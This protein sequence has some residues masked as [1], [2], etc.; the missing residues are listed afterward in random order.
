[1]GRLTE[2]WKKALATLC[3]LFH[4]H[5][6]DA[7]FE[8]G[9]ESSGTNRNTPKDSDLA[10]TTRGTGKPDSTHRPETA[11]RIEADP[12][13][14]PPPDIRPEAPNGPSDT[15]QYPFT[16]GDRAE[17]SGKSEP[18]SNAAHSEESETAH[19]TD[20]DAEPA[21]PHNESEQC[22]PGASDDPPFPDEISANTPDQPRPRASPNPKPQPEKPDTHR[23]EPAKIGAKRTHSTIRANAKEAAPRL[24][25]PE[26]ICRELQGGC[27][28]VFLK[29]EDEHSIRL[30]TQNHSTPEKP[31][32]TNEWRIASLHGDLEIETQDGSF[33]KPLHR[34]DKP[35]IFK[36]TENWQGEGRRVSRITTGYFLI[37][38]P[39][40]WQRLG[41]APVEASTCDDDDF[42]A[43]Y[44]YVEKNG[45]EQRIGFD[46]CSLATGNG[47][48]LQGIRLPDDAG[49]GDLF[50]GEVPTL[51]VPEHI[52]WVR[53]GEEKASGWKG[54]N[55]RP[56]E[57]SLAEVLDGREGRFFVR[58]YEQDERGG[59]V[60][61]DNGQF[62]YLRD[63][64]G[65]LIN[66]QAYQPDTL[67]PPSS[68]G[69]TQA[70]VEF[71]TAGQATIR[72]ALQDENGGWE[73]TADGM[74]KETAAHPGNDRLHCV[75]A[76]QGDVE[77]V[78]CLPRIWW[79]VSRGNAPPP[80]WHSKPITMTRQEF[81]DHAHNGDD[82]YLRL[83]ERFRT[84]R[85]GFDANPER[86]Y[87]P[88]TQTNYIILPC[89]DFQD[90]RCLEQPYDEAR[91]YIRHEDQTLPVI[92][93]P[94]EPKP[95]ILAFSCHPMPVRAGEAAVLSWQTRHAAPNSVTLHPDIGTVPPVGTMMVSPEATTEY[96]LKLQFQ[97]EAASST[98]R[99][100]VHPEP[101]PATTGPVSAV[102][103]VRVHGSWRQG[104]GFSLG[105]WQAAGREPHN[106]PSGA[107]DKRR[108]STHQ[109][110]IDSL[111]RIRDD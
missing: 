8:N 22:P 5:S 58:V 81:L 43:H 68:D 99:L 13:P 111:E 2:I 62:R 25:S 64:Y 92:D 7:R 100:E 98:I 51:K 38:A 69:Y 75:F 15:D 20:S 109:R 55:F 17:P 104:K 97:G 67:I 36:C 80:D 103:F 89:H 34:D 94:A 47:F 110:N 30:I 39:R 85:A 35:L 3:A 40:K 57:K 9:S 72:P 88:P 52:V 108:K 63:V 54:E 73:I 37:I 61:L 26:L 48:E 16:P 42:R 71:L 60:L 27:W 70:E 96:T 101:R 83:P 78:I 79:G 14:G 86:A 46:Q 76:E 12:T 84:I 106:L 41:N 4:K 18:D 65:I 77:I 91:F 19:A 56:E 59:N 1:M 50:I 31:S 21:P 11:A 24:K 33:P 82:L 74:V 23:P 10:E 6:P 102:A 107:I 49:Q 44:F 90:A 95:T 28:A 45:I 32:D 29:A 53:V 87:K 93:I 105:E 66:H